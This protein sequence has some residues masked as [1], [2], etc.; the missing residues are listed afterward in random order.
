MARNKVEYHIQ[1]GAFH[2]FKVQT[3][4]LKIGQPVKI[5]GDM[6]VAL[7]GAGE[8]AIGIV[9]SGTVGIDGVNVGYQASKGDVVTVIINKPLVYLPVTAS[10]TAGADLAVG[11]DGKFVTATEG[12]QVVAKALTAGSATQDVIAI[13]V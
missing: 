9:Y 7:A 11:T 1:E 4:T 13:L 2:T 6:A 3:G 12:A 5:A 10:V 8:G